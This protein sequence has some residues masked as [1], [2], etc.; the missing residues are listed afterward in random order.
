[1]ITEKE[2][3]ADLKKF[4]VMLGWKWYHPYLSIHSERGFPD[5]T[6]VK[7][8]RLIY[9]ELKSEK[10]KVTDNQQEWLDILSAIP[11][12]E[13]YL[14]RPTDEDWEEIVRVLR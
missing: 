3:M 7:P 11:G 10:G 14:W 5:V 9:A 4:A 2:F 1:M 8:P 12:V 6:L 13:V